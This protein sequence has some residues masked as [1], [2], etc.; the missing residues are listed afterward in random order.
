LLAQSLIRAALGKLWPI[1]VFHTLPM[2][3]SF[4]T[5]DPVTTLR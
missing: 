4:R 1:A 2:G 3:E 5:I